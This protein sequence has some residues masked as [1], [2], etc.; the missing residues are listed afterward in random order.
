MSSLSRLRPVHLRLLVAIADLGKLQLAAGRVA[1]SQP[2]ASRI[3]SEIEADIGSPLFERRAR[4]MHPTALGEVVLQRAALILAAFDTLDQDIELARGGLAGK[5]R[6]GTV[7][8]PASGYVM[9]AIRQLRETAPGIEATIHV[10]PSTELIRGLENRAFDFIIAR[11]P[12]GHDVSHLDVTPARNEQV[13]LLVHQTHPL[14]GQGPCRLAD[15][16]GY[17]W[18]MQERG[19]PIRQAVEN[20]FFR[21]RQPLPDRLTNSS[22]LLVALDMIT[23]GPAIAPVALEVAKLLTGPGTQA[24]LTVLQTEYPIMVG[25]YFV[26]LHKHHARS[27]VALR[28]YRHVLD[29]L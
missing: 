28:V 16:L 20:A 26:I 3:L 5:V 7:T 14:A 29:L 11:L 22:S 25:P 6:I 24:R 8:G 4:G 9:P 18:V 19:A 13:S 10:A 12:A 2:A 27:E 15:L 17:D 1:M 21:A 23:A